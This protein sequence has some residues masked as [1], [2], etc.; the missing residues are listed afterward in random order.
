MSPVA[1]PFDW[2]CR[3]EKAW[4]SLPGL[5]LIWARVQPSINFEPDAYQLECTA[6]ILNGCDIFCISMTGDGKSALIYM[7]VLVREGTITLVVSPTNFL[8]SD[9]VANLEKRGI[10]VLAINSETLAAAKLSMPVRDLWEEA[11]TGRHHVILIGPETMQTSQYNSFILDQ[12]SC[13]VRA[14]HCG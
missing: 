1:R 14:I 12:C 7:P 6:K 5:Q 10:P 9:M 13:T 11:R 8:E 3:P 4:S 2:S